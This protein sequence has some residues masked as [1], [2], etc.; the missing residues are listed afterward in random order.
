[1]YLQGVRSLGTRAFRVRISWRTVVLCVVLAGGLI[2]SNYW[3]EQNSG[4]VATQV[5]T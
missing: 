3:G 4:V 2:D 5:L 1:M